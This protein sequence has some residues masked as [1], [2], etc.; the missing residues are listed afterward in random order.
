VEISSAESGSYP[1]FGA[2]GGEGEETLQQSS[3]VHGRRA[4]GSKG[5]KLFEQPYPNPASRAMG[6]E[7]EEIFDEPETVGA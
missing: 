7:G 4:M 2:V 5:E 1:T 6:R 3:A